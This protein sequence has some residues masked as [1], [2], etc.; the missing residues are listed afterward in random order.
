MKFISSRN[1]IRISRLFIKL[2]AVISLTILLISLFNLF[3][4]P[5]KP[6][7]GQKISSLYS[8]KSFVG[9]QS[10]W[11]FHRSSS[12]SSHVSS[13]HPPSNSQISKSC[14]LINIALYFESPHGVST[15]LPII[16]KS[17]MANLTPKYKLSLHIFADSSATPV[18]QVI[19]QT[20]HIASLHNVNLYDYTLVNADTFVRWGL[21]VET[22]PAAIRNR[23]PA[24]VFAAIPKE[25]NDILVVNEYVIFNSN[26]GKL[27]DLIHT[28]PKYNSIGVV[29]DSLHPLHM[30]SDQTRTR[31]SQTRWYSDSFFVFTNLRTNRKVVD[32]LLKQMYTREATL[33]AND[34]RYTG[35]F[36]TIF[37]S[38]LSKSINL[39]KHIKQIPCHWNIQEYPVSDNSFQSKSCGCSRAASPQIIQLRHNLLSIPL[40]SQT[41]LT[42]QI[43]QCLSKTNQQ[44]RNGIYWDLFHF[45]QQANGY[46]Y[47]LR[48]LISFNHHCQSNPSPPISTQSKSHPKSHFNSYTPL[49]HYGIT[50]PATLHNVSPLC[51]S[52]AL[53]QSRRFRTVPYVIHPNP[54]SVTSP[55][56]Q[57]DV[58]LATHGSFSDIS[59]FSAILDA[60]PGPISFTVYVTDAVARV[61]LAHISDVIHKRHDVAVH[62]V[63]KF[64]DDYPGNLLRSVSAS[65][66]Q[67]P[68]VLI[69]DTG[70]VPSTRMYWNLVMNVKSREYKERVESNTSKKALLVPIIDAKSNLKVANHSE[71]FSLI[72]SKKASLLKDSSPGIKRLW[73][74]LKT[75][76]AKI[77]FHK[78]FAQTPAVLIPARRWFFDSHVVQY[79]KDWLLFY[80]DL[81]VEG[82]SFYLSPSAFALR[83]GRYQHHRVLHSP[84]VEAESSCEGLVS[85]HVMLHR[86]KHH[87]FYITAG[88]RGSSPTFASLADTWYY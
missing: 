20:W 81:H 70:L 72:Q 85:Q 48:D 42:S 22:I 33:R 9:N 27:F 56:H 13:N 10:L 67:T 7:K 15:R 19:L 43:P 1:L 75:G 45:Y 8:I 79:R 38:D 60:W 78:T 59:H 16:I 47:T 18:A 83:D 54:I 30:S 77:Q 82:Y 57:C 37:R 3:I 65:L 64:G 86:Q 11:P 73:P 46:L 74:G 40:I 61:A 62:F 5:S 52:S 80:E 51:R 17:L 26:V 2:F 34:K 49:D 31:K 44:P 12:H 29:E 32:G 24:I 35:I 4:Y 69:M 63:Y 36:S 71:V 58:T 14:G 28:F 23:I 6:S 66:I 84:R 41:S 53:L 88:R 21:A 76:L 50:L 25:I 68:Y 39:V 55:Q 87:N